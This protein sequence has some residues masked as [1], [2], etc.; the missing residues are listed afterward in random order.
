MVRLTCKSLIVLLT[1]A[2]AS[3]ADKD[4][5][6]QKFAPG[7]VT[8]YP[9]RQTTD[10]VTVAAEPFET[11]AKA[12]LAFGKID[13]NQHGVLPVLIVIRNDKDETLSLERIEVEFVTPD[14]ER[15]DATPPADVRYI[16]SRGRPGVY[17]PPVP[18]MPPRV[19]RRKNPLDVWEIEGRAF[20]AKMLPAKESAGGFVYFQAP[21]RKGSTVL[22]KGLREASTGKELFYFEIPLND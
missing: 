2:L 3:A 1:V 9:S 14:R 12:K 11:A 13:P 15:V 5:D 7:P 16:G 19:G 4:K 22:V 8:D 10:N 20:A 17:S 18:G 6:R 21:Y